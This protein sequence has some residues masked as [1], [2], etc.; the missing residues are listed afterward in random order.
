[1]KR[2]ISGLSIEGQGELQKDYY[3]T[4]LGAVDKSPF[5]ELYRSRLERIAAQE[6]E[7]NGPRTDLATFTPH[8]E[9]YALVTRTIALSA[10]DEVVAH[11]E[12]LLAL[13]KKEQEEIYLKHNLKIDYH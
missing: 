10:S 6:Q 11:Q 4:V 1:M 2:P 13:P 12:H 5:F 3:A 7:K 9:F 8:E